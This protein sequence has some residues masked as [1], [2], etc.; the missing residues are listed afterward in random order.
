MEA[1]DRM[2]YS[3]IVENHEDPT[4]RMINSILAKSNYRL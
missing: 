1:F 3:D 4:N 2:L